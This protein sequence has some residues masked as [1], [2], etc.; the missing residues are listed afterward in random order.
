MP[1]I[2]AVN[3]SLMIDGCR[4]IVITHNNGVTWTSSRLKSQ[5]KRLV[6]QQYVY[7][8]HKKKTPTLRITGAL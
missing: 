8:N 7:A 6:S 1:D 3:T 5:A 2:E 4:G